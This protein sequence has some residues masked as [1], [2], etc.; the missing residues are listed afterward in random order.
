[1]AS[2]IRDWLRTVAELAIFSGLRRAEL[3][4]LRW[5]GLDETSRT[6]TVRE[7]VYE[8]T[9]NTPKTTGGLRQ[10]SFGGECALASRP[11]EDS[12]RQTGRARRAG[13]LDAVRQAARAEQRPAPVDH[14]RNPERLVAIADRRQRLIPF[15]TS[16]YALF[17]ARLAA[18]RSTV[19]SRLELEAESVALRHQLTV[20]QRHMPRRPRLGRADRLLWLVLSRV[21]PDWRPAV[22]IVTPDTVVRWH[23][24]GFALSWW[25]QS[26]PRRVGR[27]AVNHDIRTLIRQMHAANPLWGAPRLHGD[28]RKLGLEIA[29]TTV[30]TYLRQRRGKPPCQT[31]R[32]LLTHHVSQLASVDC[33]TVPS[34]TFRVLLVFVILSHDRRRVTHVHVT[35]HPTAAWTAQQLREAWPWDRAPRFVIRD[36]DGI[37]G[38]DFQ[39]TMRAMGIAEVVIAPRAPWQNPFVERVIGSRRRECLDRVIVGN[40]RALRR[41]LQQDLAYYHEWRTHL[42]LEKDAPVPRAVPSPTCGTIVQIPPLGGWHQHDERRAA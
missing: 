32:T 28:L 26:R 27:P 25:W 10:I 5:Q 39:A 34:A 36:R 12:S 22:R 35:A 20:L 33:F 6:L 21:W 9:F 40:E 24:R 4:A 30:A 19:R 23:R 42:S 1:V 14:T 3:F 37:Y 7:A 17:I 8:G 41:H 16:M 18:L 31:W 11:V 15:P 13:V 2:L 38:P 29:P